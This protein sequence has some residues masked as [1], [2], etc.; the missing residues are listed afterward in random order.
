MIKTK[1]DLLYYLEEDRK[2]YGKP[3]KMTFKERIL[4]LFFPDSNY[5]YMRCIRYLEYLANAKVGGGN[6]HLMYVLL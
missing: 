5:E 1:A 3:L 6:S 2:A 4:N